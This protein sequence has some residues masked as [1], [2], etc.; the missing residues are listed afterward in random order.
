MELIPGNTV[1]LHLIDENFL[2]AAEINEKYSWKDKYEVTCY[3]SADK[4]INDA[5][6]MPLSPKGTHIVIMAVHLGN[7]DSKIIN[8]LID[9]LNS[10]FRGIYII[11]VCHDKEPAD[12]NISRSGNVIRVINNENAMMRIDNAIRWVLAKTNLDRMKRKYKL[13]MY[14][15][16]ISIFISV[17]IFSFFLLPGI[18]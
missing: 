4:F 10:M 1:S 2:F 16:I 12:D 11:R 5:K 6:I 18:K 14:I 9:L 3:P 13:A 8:E 15:L 7:P 17:A